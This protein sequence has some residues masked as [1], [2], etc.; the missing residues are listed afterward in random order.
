MPPIDLL[1]I[2]NLPIFPKISHKCIKQQWNSELYEKVYKRFFEKFKNNGQLKFKIHSTFILKKFWLFK[3]SFSP[4]THL[5]RKWR[6]KWRKSV[7]ISLTIFNISVS[8]IECPA[9]NLLFAFH[10]LKN[11]NKPSVFPSPMSLHEESD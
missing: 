7:G 5:W 9:D 10:R 6:D 1:I 8:K 3:L 4:F 2:K 11:S